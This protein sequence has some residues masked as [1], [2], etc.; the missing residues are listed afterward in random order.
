M[1][2][3]LIGVSGDFRIRIRFDI[4]RDRFAPVFPQIVRQREELLCVGRT[5]EY[6]ALI[7][8]VSDQ[9]VSAL[10]LVPYERRRNEEH[11]HVRIRMVADFMSSGNDLLSLLKVLLE[12]SAGYEERSLHIRFGESGKNLICGFGSWAVIKRESYYFLRC[13]Y[14]RNDLAK[15]LKRTR[16]AYL[17]QRNWNNDQQDEDAERNTFLHM[18][19]DASFI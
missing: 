8:S 5:K 19:L 9:F 4:P 14:S 6:L 17:S 2:D 3:N 13:V 18:T 10:N 15:E 11:S 16:A 7:T 1:F 12:F